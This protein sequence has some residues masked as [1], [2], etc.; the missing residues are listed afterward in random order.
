MA[1]LRVAPPLSVC[2]H[3]CRNHRAA[4]SHRLHAAG[5]RDHAGHI[6]LGAPH[7]W[8]T[9]ASPARLRPSAKS[10]ILISQTHLR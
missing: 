2:L 3:P 4:V 7:R 6:R 9:E 1:G 10:L 5:G 8:V